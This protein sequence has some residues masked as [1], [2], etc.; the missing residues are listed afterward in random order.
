MTGDGVIKTIYIRRGGG[1]APHGYVA[2][3]ETC[4]MGGWLEFIDGEAVK[5]DFDRWKER[6]HI[7]VWEGRLPRQL[8]E[9]Q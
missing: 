7:F 6:E 4:I 3:L 1:Y 9:C 2:G 5:R 8:D